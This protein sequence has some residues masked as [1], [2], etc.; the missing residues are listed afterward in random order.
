M[1]N[2]VSRRYG[3]LAAEGGITAD[4]G[5]KELA[6]RLDALLTALCEARTRS[7][8]SS[9]GWLF[10]RSGAP[11]T[12]PGLYIHG[13]VGR[14]KTMLMDIFF[15]LAPNARKRR[16]HFNDFMQDVQE[17]IALFRKRLKA[18]EVDGDDPIKPVAEEIAQETRLLCFD[19]FAVTDIADAMILGRLFEKLFASGLTLVATSNV[20][21]DELYAG[22]LNRALFLPFI[23]LIK[24]NAEIFHL[25][26]A[27]D[28]RQDRE[29]THPLYVVPPGPKAEE[30]LAAH[31]VRLTGREKG[32]RQEIALRGRQIEVPEAAE[33]VAR[34]TFSELCERPLGSAD[35]LKLASRFHTFIVSGIPVLGSERRN[36]AKRFINLVDT[37][38]DKRIRLMASA[39]AEP[40]A[41]FSGTSGAEAMEFVRT[42]SRLAE[43]RSDD[44][45][46]AARRE[47]RPAVAKAGN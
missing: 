16:A 9:L 36:E 23:D 28:F 27:R 39:E 26:A 34:F 24:E 29:R 25:D 45:P 42:A 32:E 21:P 11:Q 35:Y 17:R 8:R 46:E 5:Q 44:W 47:E 6:E 22:G 1:K 13:P 12:V 40:E 33:G 4:P 10:S 15:E 19:E 37:L 18:G 3:E 14:G 2:P 30:V 43:M 38:Y 31:F 7:K 20:A 41:L